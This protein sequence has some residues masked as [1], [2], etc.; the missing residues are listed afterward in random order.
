MKAI[1][2]STISSIIVNLASNAIDGQKNKWW[3][4][5]KFRNFCKNNEKWLECFCIE[6]D[7]SVVLTHAFA[8]Y[9][10]CHDPIER[11]YSFVLR[12]DKANVTEEAFIRELVLEC[13]NYI[14]E[15]QGNCSINDELILKNLF[16]GVLHRL[17]K[18]L[19]SCL[20]QEQKYAIYCQRK[21][22]ATI[23]EKVEKQTQIS[24]QGFSKVIGLLEARDRITDTE[25]ILNIY[26][27]INSKLEEGNITEVYDILPLLQGKN[28]DLELSVK[29]SLKIVADTDIS[30]INPWNDLNKINNGEIRDDIIRK[31]LLLNFEDKDKLERLSGKAESSQLNTILEKIIKDDYSDFFTVN[32]VEKNYVEVK[33]FKFENKFDKE[34]WLVRRISFCYLCN[35]SMH[36]KAEVLR[37]L[38]AHKVNYIENLYLLEK[39]MVEYIYDNFKREGIADISSQLKKDKEKYI[40]SCK[41]IQEKYYDV[42]LRALVMTEPKEIDEVRDEIPLEI[43]N[44]QEIKELLIRA[45][46]CCNK[47]TEE[48]VIKHC[49]GTGKYFVLGEYLEQKKKNPND[50]LEILNKYNFI[51][52]EDTQIFLTYL[53]A[54]LEVEGKAK[55]KELLDKYQDNHKDFLEYW[56]AMLRVTRNKDIVKFILGKWFKNELKW[57]SVF[58][59]AELAEILMDLEC[60]DEVEELIGR[61]DTLGRMS[62]TILRMKTRML[63]K[64]GHYLD[65]LNILNDIFEHYKTDAYVV[66]NI[67]VL[68]LNNKRSVS[69]EVLDA[70]LERGTSRL[71]RV[72]ANVYMRNG[73]DAEAKKLI[74]KALLMAT[75]DELDAY[76]VYFGADVRESANAVRQIS[77]VDSDTAVYLKN[78]CT[79][80]VKIYCI[81]GDEVLPKEPYIWE[82]SEH[83]YMDTAIE[84]GLIRHKKGDEITIDGEG[85]LVIDIIPVEAYLFRTCM[86]KLIEHGAIKSFSLETSED[87]VKNTDKFVEWIKENITERNETFDWIENYKDMN[88]IP[89]PFYFLGKYKRIT[90]EQI[91]SIILEEKDL[92]IRELFLPEV[93][94]GESFVLSLSALIILYKLGVSVESLN[95][96]DSVISDSMIVELKEE[97]EMIIEDN[98]KEHVSSMGVQDDHLIM[99]ITSEEEK[100]KWMSE[101]IG[102]KKYSEKMKTATNKKDIKIKELE[103][104]ELNEFFGV[105]DN[106]VIAIAKDTKRILVTAEVLI[107]QI[108][109]LDEVNVPAI[110]ILEFLCRLNLDVLDLLAYMKRMIE[111]RFLIALNKTAIEI[112][113]NGFRDGDEKRREA[114]A[115]SWEEFLASIGETEKEYKEYFIQIFNEVISRLKVE[116]IDR[117]DFVLFRLQYFALKY[118]NIKLEVSINDSLEMEVKA[119]K[120]EIVENRVEESCLVDE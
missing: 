65:A 42:L 61:I 71:L 83:I 16:E 107:M 23:D 99:Q 51:I 56:M 22:S 5:I 80:V 100:Q 19:D 43:K 41:R 68:S 102:I 70:A 94:E 14:I 32:V 10:K 8:T 45:D 37:E 90:Y 84:K 105:C 64:N 26:R 52:E 67:I 77:G 31:L 112:I 39:Q 74:T 79:D 33:E 24:Q 7:G 109:R 89:L 104:L 40:N 2:I 116:Q 28:T 34:N 110:G 88:S 115:I 114:I 76:G 20:T 44:K 120:Q 36:I 47:V 62:P 17:K 3:K 53:Q 97:S 111:Y 57:F 108:A 13:K 96:S 73:Q 1:I 9:L 6:N 60:Y 95:L 30:D 38:L 48:E 35:R 101:A 54:E 69:E 82:D 4:K 11:I 91:V 12:D 27:V 66:D 85:Y 59:D 46:V 25:I 93:V 103:K 86:K 98:N 63:I 75:E 118:N 92:I 119:R 18:Y 58:A 15:S 113:R 72:V 21:A 49:V 78:K 55:V 29:C 50:I 87:G 106:D 117:D 81:Y